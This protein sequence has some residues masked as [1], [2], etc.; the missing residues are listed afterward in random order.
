MTA[1]VAELAR[2]VINGIAATIV[3]YGVLTLNL[4]WLGFRSAG[5]A[6]LVA[7]FFGITA[8]FLGSRYCV[9]RN[10]SASIWQQAA[11]FGSLYGAIAVLH[12]AVLWVWTDWW[13]FDH[14]VGF[15]IATALQMSLS[16]LGNKYLVFK[17]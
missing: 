10:R 5:A 14:R 1:H 6:N 2:Y 17:S 13:G 11:G 16:Y 15:C 12:G 4:E 9:F 7:A 3:H 8:S